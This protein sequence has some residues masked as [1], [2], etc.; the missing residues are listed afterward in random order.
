MKPDP[1]IYLIAAENVQAL[2]ENCLYID[3]L[4]D[5]V[6]AARTAGMTAVR[7]ENT[8]QLKTALKKFKL[9]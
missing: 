8:A 9:L 5:N 7:F 4:E 3:D 6:E 2:P 1:I